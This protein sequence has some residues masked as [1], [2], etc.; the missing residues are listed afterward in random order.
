MT[1]YQQLYRHDPDNGVYGDCLRTVVGCLLDLMPKTVPHF[2]ESRDW[3]THLQEWLN[4]RGLFMFSVPFAGK[5]QDVLRT[6]GL[7]NPGV[8]C[9]LVGTSKNNLS[10][11]VIIKDGQIVHDPS[12]DQSGIVG[13]GEDGYYQI[14]VLAYNKHKNSVG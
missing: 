4:E 8:Y 10:H 2:V 7:H 13:P 11:C 6:V 9:I 5:L 1:P 12:I 14:E 3:Y